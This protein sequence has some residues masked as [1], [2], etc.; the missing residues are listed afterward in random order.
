M[1]IK[2]NICSFH[3]RQND[4]QSGGCEIFEVKNGASAPIQTLRLA[5]AVAHERQTG[6]SEGDVPP[7]EG[8]AFLKV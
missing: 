6:M 8:G 1:E 5:S 2:F 3:A 4:F 7:L